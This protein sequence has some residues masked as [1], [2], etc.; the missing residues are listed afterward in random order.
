MRVQ[1][2]PGQAQLVLDEMQT[3]TD[4]RPLFRVCRRKSSEKGT[5]GAIFLI[6]REFEFWT[7]GGYLRAPTLVCTAVLVRAYHLEYDE[8]HARLRVLCTVIN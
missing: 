4:F 1:V 7:K 6:T 2:S 5:R 8:R 3:T